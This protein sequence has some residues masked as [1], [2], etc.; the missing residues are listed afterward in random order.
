MCE[1]ADFDD[2]LLTPYSRRLLEAELES[3][4]TS[5]LP[6]HG[7]VLDVGAG[8]GETARFYLLHGAEQVIAIE[9]Y[10]PAFARL[11]ANFRDDHRVLPLHAYV[12]KVKVDIEGAE[13][14]MD[15]SVHFPYEW[16]ILTKHSDGIDIRLRC[17]GE[18]MISKAAM[19]RDYW[20]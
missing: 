5:Y 14:G 1:L 16:E 8:C 11:L 13:E 9:S 2:L 19:Q 20:R 3:W 10:P 17:T 15:I 18:S 6:V 7:T 12:D 4:H